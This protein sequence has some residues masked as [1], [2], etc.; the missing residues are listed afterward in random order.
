MVNGEWR[1]FIVL[2]FDHFHLCLFHILWVSR[3]IIIT[4][5]ANR[6][7]VLRLLLRFSDDPRLC[8]KRQRKKIGSEVEEPYFSSATVLR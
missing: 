5:E 4:Y 1:L 2:D 6:G 8:D 7:A 3:R